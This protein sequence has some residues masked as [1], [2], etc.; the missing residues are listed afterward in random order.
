MTCCVTLNFGD[1]VPHW[2][3]WLGQVVIKLQVWTRTRTRSASFHHSH[4]PSASSQPALLLGYGTSPD[5]VCPVLRVNFPCS[6]CMFTPTDP[7]H[8]SILIRDASGQSR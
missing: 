4:T 3:L 6:L 7:L 1:L 2:T 5:M 8:D